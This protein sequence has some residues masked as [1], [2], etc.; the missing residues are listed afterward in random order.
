MA[1]KSRDAIS[2]VTLSIAAKEPPVHARC[3]I[4]QFRFSL[5]RSINPPIPPSMESL[6]LVSEAG[7]RANCQHIQITKIPEEIPLPP[8]SATSAI[9]AAPTPDPSFAIPIRTFFSPAT[10]TLGISLSVSRMY[11]SKF[12]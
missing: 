4:V 10:P 9:S 12:G 11:S 7:S 6:R 8:L 3:L 5:K 1:H 2:R